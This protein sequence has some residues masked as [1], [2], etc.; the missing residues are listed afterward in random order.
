MNTSDN[1][2]REITGRHVAIAFVAFFGLIIIADVIMVR[3]AIT[4]FG[5]VETTDAYRKGLNYNENIEI[6]RAMANRGW[7]SRAKFDRDHRT[8]V[9]QLADADGKPLNHL[10]VAVELGRAATNRYDKALQLKL[11]ND[12]SFSA[13]WPEAKPG[14]WI[15]STTVKDRDTVVFRAKERLWIEP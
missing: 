2:D 9:V 13:A 15:V 1:A 8:I 4:T 10:N 3:L 11:N 6:S 14:R 5:G 12:D 7:Q